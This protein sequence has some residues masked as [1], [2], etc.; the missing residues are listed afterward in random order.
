MLL[1]FVS[2]L[3]HIDLP[4]S[5]QLATHTAAHIIQDGAGKTG[6]QSSG[7]FDNILE[8]I[9]K[10]LIF[11]VGAISVIAIIVGGLRYVTS[12]GNSSQVSS[13]KDTILYAVVGLVVAMAAFGIVEFVVKRFS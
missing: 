13:A 10:F 3:Q 7:S 12:G 6:L 5:A 8:D 4:S 2:V 9:A 11:L 1:E